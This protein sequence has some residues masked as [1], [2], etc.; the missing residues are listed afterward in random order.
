MTSDQKDITAK[1]SEIAKI[2]RN[3]R[4]RPAL[5]IGGKTPLYI[6]DSDSYLPLAG[7]VKV[8]RKAMLAY[9]TDLQETASRQ[10]D[11]RGVELVIKLS[12]LDH[13]YFV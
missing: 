12:I 7:N 8:S 2:I 4:N 6:K 13:C 3:A 11:N 5:F 10:E 9:L 1:P